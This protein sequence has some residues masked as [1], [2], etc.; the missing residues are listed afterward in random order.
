MASYYP[1]LSENLT[2]LS[3]SNTATIC[4]FTIGVGWE[5]DSSPSRRSVKAYQLLRLIAANHPFVDGNKRT[6][7][8]S[9]RIFYALNDRRFDYDREIKEILKALATDQQ[10][11]DGDERTPRSIRNPT[12]RT[13]I[14]T[15]PILR[16]KYGR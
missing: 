1:R 13:I 10:G 9:T 3:R 15:T 12:N 16:S 5:G 8:M 11:V 6:A 14:T 7:L 4:E 2:E